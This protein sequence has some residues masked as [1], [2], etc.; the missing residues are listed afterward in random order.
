MSVKNRCKYGAAIFSV[1]EYRRRQYLVEIGKACF[2]QPY[3]SVE[4]ACKA[5]GIP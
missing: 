5:A 2:W 1:S 3:R 4:Q